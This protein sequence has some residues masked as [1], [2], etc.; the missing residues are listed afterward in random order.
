MMKQLL[1]RFLTQYTG[2]KKE[3]YILFLGRIVTAMGSFV[4]PMMTFFLTAKLGFSDDTA[5]L[6]L[7]AVTLVQLPASIIGG[8]LSDLFSRKKLI[9]LFDLMT[10]LL[11]TLSAI[12][13]IGYHT[14]V[15]IFFAGL[16]QTIEAPA[17]DALNADYSTTDDRE[18]AFSLSYLGFNVGYII[19]ATAA[20]ML[21]VNHTGLAFFLNGL[22]VFVSTV[23]IFFF[24]DP[25]NA[26]NG[27]EV[28]TEEYGPYEEPVELNRS[29][30]SVL[31]ERPVIITMMLVACLSSLPSI[32]LGIILPL[33]LGNTYGDGGAVLYG[34]LSSVN[35]FVVILLTPILS[36]LLRRFTEIPKTALGALLFAGGMLLFS[37]DRIV[38]VLFLGMFVFTSGEVAQVL[39]LNPYV[40]RRIPA[41]HRGRVS[42]FENVT[43]SL[44][45]SGIQFLISLAL[46]LTGSNYI[47]IWVVFAL[48]EVLTAFIAA[49]SYRADRRTF[50]KLYPTE[51][52]NVNGSAELPPGSQV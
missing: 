11:Y 12:V 17:Y 52:K 5:A 21:F 7:A 6:L 25:K 2:L 28:E 29:T 45:S 27:M 31:R 34:T 50:P 23:L 10:V 14:A 36:V 47:L 48:I 37:F 13:P 3:I 4:Y 46:A 38:A 20:G 41:S 8:K 32:L 22:S 39:G 26:V 33:Q 40:S 9:I 19:G 49:L 35:G 18:R 51:K 30:F 44:V 1:K 43:F 15:M 24:V 16:F 42:G